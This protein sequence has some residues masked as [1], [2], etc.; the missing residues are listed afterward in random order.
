[1]PGGRWAFAGICVLLLLCCAGYCSIGSTATAEAAKHGAPRHTAFAPAA[2]TGAFGLDLLGAQPPGN[3]VLSPDSVAAALAMAGTGADGRTA[4]QIARG[5]RLK[6]PAAFD[7]VGNLQHVIAGAQASAGEGHPQAPTLA[8]ANG[9]FLQQGFPVEPSFIG[10]LQ[11]HF[12]ATPEALDFAGDP[13]GSAAA[14]NSWV[15]E[16]TAGIIPALLGELPMET[17]LVLTNAVYLKAAWQHPFYRADTS[18]ASFHLH[19]GVTRVEFMHQIERL[20]YGSGPYYKAVELPYRAS[21]MSLLVVL[22]VG[23]GVGALQ[24]QLGRGGLGGVVRSLSPETVKLSLPRFHLTAQTGLEEA[25]K[26]LG[27]AASFS[28]AADFSGITTA[29]PLKLDTVEHAADLS[30]DEEGTVAAAATGVVAIPVSAPLIPPDAVTFNANRPFL[31]FLRDNST[32]AVLFAG[33]LTN[34]ATASPD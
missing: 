32:G 3:T 29:V 18:P 20:R 19:N 28:N 24:H 4:A 10:G 31:F 12:G 22:P 34:P 23:E 11:R 7:L 2:A 14:I 5:L 33:R 8:L 17:R 6:G 15:S 25:L 13:A 1:M 9:L 30:V 21:T 16:H 27:M 26:S